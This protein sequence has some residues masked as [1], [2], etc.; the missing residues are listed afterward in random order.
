MIH[1]VIKIGL[2]LL[3]STSEVQRKIKN[4]QDLKISTDSAIRSALWIS[5]ISGK[6][7]K[8][9]II[10]FKKANL[11]ILKIETNFAYDVLPKTEQE[12]AFLEE[13]RG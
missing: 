6:L 5:K 10:T 1:E 4:V 3:H 7:R 8:L 12:S 9:W 11:P 2:F 13:T